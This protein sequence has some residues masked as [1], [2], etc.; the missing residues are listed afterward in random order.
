MTNN[1]NHQQKRIL[2]VDNEPDITTVFSIA[3][4]EY[5]FEAYSFNNPKMAYQILSQIGLSYSSRCWHCRI[6]IYQHR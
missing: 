1:N 6:C 5:G 3:L 4:K 2:I